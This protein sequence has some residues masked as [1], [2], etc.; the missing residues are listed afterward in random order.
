LEYLYNFAILDIH[1]L[2]ARRPDTAGRVEEIGLVRLQDRLVIGV[3]ERAPE[4]VDAGD[5]KLNVSVIVQYAAPPQLAPEVSN[6]GWRVILR[7]GRR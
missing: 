1:F 7:F 5:E 3:F 2:P 6:R 4:T